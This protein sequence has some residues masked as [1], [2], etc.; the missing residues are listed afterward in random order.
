MK[1][2]L[3]LILSALSFLQVNA[4]GQFT[5]EVPN[6]V[7]TGE[8]FRLVFTATDLPHEGF[9]PPKIDGFLVLAGPTTSTMNRMEYI[10]GRR[11]QS[12]SISYT[13][14][15]E[16][17]TT[18]K[19]T[20]G[21]ASVVS[22]DVTYRT[23]PMTVEVIQR[24]SATTRPEQEESTTATTEV[25]DKD[26]FLRLTINKRKVV[27]G[28]PLT[29]TLRLYTRVNVA[30]AEDIRFPT[31]NGFWSQEVYAPQ[32]IEWQREN[33]EG[34]IY[35]VATL[36]SYVLLPQQTGEIRIDPSE[37]VCVIQ[38]RNTRR[39][40]SLLDEFF[41]TY[42]T[43]R[44]RVIAPAVTVRVS[45]LPAGAPPSF[46]G[47]VGKFSL[48]TEM[49]KDSIRS[50][51]AVSMFV[52]IT[53]E[54]N[55]N[56]LEVPR[57][58]FPPDFEVYDARIT[59][60]SRSAGGTFS[61]SKIFEYPVIPRSHGEF[62]IEPVVF[63]Y[64]DIEA[65]HYKT[66]RSSPLTIKVGRSP[67]TLGPGVPFTLGTHRRSVESLAQDVRYIYVAMPSWRTKGKYFT[68]S[69]F[70][71]ILLS[72]IFAVTGGLYLLLEKRRVRRSDVIRVRN[73]KANKVARTRL[74]KAGM[75]L[76][77]Q[78]FEGYYEELHRALWG[79]IADKLALS[80]ADCSREKVTEML[81]GRDVDEDLIK[82]YT[83]LIE[84][85]EFAR[86]APDPGQMEKERIFE[87]AVTAISKMEQALK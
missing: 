26:V 67:E 83:G 10:N 45:D 4:Q 25:S 7:A 41:D 66:L 43:V 35:Q 14:I 29:A 85:C 49:S 12:R 13:Y 46:S 57:V 64:Y 31:F 38:V 73:S 23:Q 24:T 20:I 3:L 1:R 39:A 59:D 69:V 70:Y 55:I 17:I 80:Q 75:L 27:K 28:E 72:G 52:T 11:T 82:D 2:I 32:Q 6:V 78:L 58:Q 21:E 60:N 71:F 84:S 16:A 9:N 87:K 15:L 77:Q 36:R 50:H 40:Q 18:G 62:T 34:E 54:G 47:A 51:D 81:T 53:G 74:K 22:D 30:G 37:I 65:G 76:K 56:L 5:V 44:K 61:G 79:Y 68:G 63:S 33:V 19:Y 48:R 8:R 86:Y 42:Q